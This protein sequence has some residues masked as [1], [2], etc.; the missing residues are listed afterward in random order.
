MTCLDSLAMSFRGSQHSS[1][2]KTPYEMVYGKMMMLPSD[3][4]LKLKAQERA[5]ARRQNGEKVPEEIVP[6]PSAPTQ[7]ELFRSMEQVRRNIHD[8]AV[9][10]IAAAQAKQCKNYDI[11]HMG[12]QIE[13]GDQVLWY[14]KRE[15]D[16]K[17]N[18]LAFDWRGPF[19][20]VEISKSK[21]YTLADV[22]GRVLPNKAVAKHLKKFIKG[23]SQPSQIKPDDNFDFMDNL[24]TGNFRF[25]RLWC[26]CWTANGAQRSQKS[27]IS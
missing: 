5:E 25:F 20:V 17:G 19:T 16:R 6:P 12:S 26:V 7:G 10:N 3:I 14:N 15:K 27:K 9:I 2:G 4:S 22:N 1:T 13:V 24:D 11:R 21:N 8:A 23:Y 18:K